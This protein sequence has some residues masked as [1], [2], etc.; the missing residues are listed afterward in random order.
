MRPNPA[1]KTANIAE[2]LLYIY[3]I[4]AL[5]RSLN[6]DLDLIKAQ[7]LVPSTQNEQELAEH[8]NWYAQVIQ[9]FKSRGLQKEGHIEEV[10]EV[11]MEL[12][13]LHNTL[14]TIVNDEKY[15]T[16]CEQAQTDLQE[17]K[18][19]S[20]MAQRQDIEVLLHAMFMKLQLKMKK[21]EI[22]SETEAAFDLF[23]IQLA[24]LSKAYHDM[25]TGALNF[26]QN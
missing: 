8:L 5:L 7:F 14:L 11:L 23:R 13:Y 25:K 2:Y 21:Q 3:Q 18:K 24:Y 9:E 10:E 15:K 4:E 20:N 12:I 22:S 26:F 19:R 17:F 16:L 6:L 1:L